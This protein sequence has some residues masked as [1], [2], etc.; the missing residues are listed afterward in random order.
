LI[1]KYYLGKVR[2]H[3]TIIIKTVPVSSYG[4]TIL[5]NYLQGLIKHAISTEEFI[6]YNNMRQD[7]D[8][9]NRS[10]ISDETYCII[11]V[12]ICCTDLHPPPVLLH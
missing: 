8:E 12:F 1:F 5:P 11:F 2:S 6:W 4:S 10:P 7:V 3:P 9:R